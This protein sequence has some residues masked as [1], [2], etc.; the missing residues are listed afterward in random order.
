LGTPEKYFYLKKRTPNTN[1]MK[2]KNTPNI[3]IIS[4]LAIICMASCEGCSDSEAKKANG[5][6]TK[7]S[8]GLTP[9]QMK[10]INTETAQLKTVANELTLTG[11]VQFNEDKIVKVFPLVGGHIEDVKVELGDYVQKGQT[12]AII[13]S[14]DLADLQQQA[15]TAKTQLSVAQK[16]AQVAEDLAKGGLY[17]QKDL[18]AAQE[19]L[20]A[21]TGEVNRVIERQNILGGN[22]SIYTVK[23][24][25]GGYVVEKKAAPGMEL[26]SDDPENL[27]TISNLD[28]VWI[29]ANVYETDLANVKLGYEAN[30]SILAY[31]NKI[32]K[33]RIDKI[34]NVLDPIS[35]TEQVRIVLPNNDKNYF[36][37]PEMY[38]NVYL[39]FAGVEQKVSIPSKAVIFDK[40][41]NYVVVSKD[42]NNL[43]VKP[44]DVYK[45][46][47]QTVYLN[48]GLTVNEKVVT[49]NQLL[50]YQ[51]LSQ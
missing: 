7:N 42:A 25:V 12:L 34:F 13:R 26:R 40:S 14:G 4:L 39:E 6:D 3:F 38:A 35:K 43:I 46:I 44:I 32:F 27:F 21:A 19:Q 37:K 22:N 33:G 11:K 5:A 9:E 15:V 17:S 48:S 18:V 47:G 16:N 28:Q 29:L 1:K 23:A 24:P 50:I 2:T 10:N 45:T 51:A 49:E 8:S 20:R 31:P 36:L 30:I 41:Q